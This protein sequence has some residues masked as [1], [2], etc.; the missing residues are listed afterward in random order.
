MG[1][2]YKVR[3]NGYSFPFVKFFCASRRR[4]ALPWW[5]LPWA[6]ATVADPGLLRGYSRARP[7]PLAPVARTLARH[8]RHRP[9]GRAPQDDAWMQ[10]ASR[11]RFSRARP[12][13]RRDGAASTW[14][15]LLALLPRLDRRARREA[16]S[17]EASSS[18]ATCCEA[19]CC[20]A[21]SAA[22]LA[23]RFLASPFSLS[24][25]SS[26]MCLASVWTT[27]TWLSSGRPFGPALLLSRVLGDA[28][29]RPA[30]PWAPP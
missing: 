10:K 6:V 18:E 25:R 28:C 14:R 15:P 29:H 24:R 30:P 20:E 3:S 16:S 19:T 9:V 13:G 11:A 7:L 23:T 21:T 5:P 27:P 2:R 4:S 22:A 8:A 26:A 1:G 12:A 17:S